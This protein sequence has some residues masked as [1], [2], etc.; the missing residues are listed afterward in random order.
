VVELL[1]KL[2]DIKYIHLRLDQQHSLLQGWVMLKCLYWVAV[3]VEALVSLVQV[4]L[5]LDCIHHLFLL[6]QIKALL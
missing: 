5:D 2:V 3:V 4:L 1:L 6:I